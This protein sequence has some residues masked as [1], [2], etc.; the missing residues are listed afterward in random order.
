MVQ[1]SQN[2]SDVMEKAS[3]RI[4]AQYLDKMA[5]RMVRAL[6]DEIAKMELR[7]DK[8]KIVDFVNRKGLNSSMLNPDGINLYCFKSADAAFDLD[9]GRFNFY[10]MVMQHS[11]ELLD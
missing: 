3:K 9:Y 10:S 7:V 6:G 11:N 1:N 8:N 2:F 5:S 4:Y